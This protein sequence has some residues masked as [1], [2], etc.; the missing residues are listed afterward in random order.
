MEY[1]V[2]KYSIAY[3]AEAAAFIVMF[4]VVVVFGSSGSI[5]AADALL[6]TTL[7]I[8][9][10]F[11]HEFSHYI[12]AKRFNPNAS[13]RVLPKL[14]AI[15]LDYASLNYREYIY[16]V[17]A[18]VLTVQAPITALFLLMHNSVLLLLALTHAMASAVDIV[19]L[20]Y[21]FVVH[22]GG[23]VHIVYDERGNIAGVLVEEP[24][25]GRATL[26]ML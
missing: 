13:I 5:T 21:M 14:G 10:A 1:I 7:F 18:P 24:A 9:V 25:K 6:A 3:I 16:V 23:R 8:P 15:V 20:I 12:V 17:L 26:Y 11:V 2:R 19:G 22:R 4:L